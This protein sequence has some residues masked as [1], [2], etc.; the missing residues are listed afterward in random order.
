VKDIEAIF[1]IYAKAAQIDFKIDIKQDESFWNDLVSINLIINNLLTNAF[2]YQRKDE[3]YKK[4]TLSIE[5]FRGSTTIVVADN[6]TGID[7]KYIGEIYDLFFRAHV[8]ESGSGLGLFNVKSAVSRL[9]GTID[10]NSTL[11]EGTTFTVVI[12]HK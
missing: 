5:V 7:K 6:G 3:R 8:Q 4:V 11:N 12:P 9:N 2:K 10:V 1:A